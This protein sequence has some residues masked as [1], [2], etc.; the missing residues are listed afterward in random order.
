[1]IYITLSYIK[2]DLRAGVLQRIS[3][4]FVC[5]RKNCDSLVFPIQNTIARAEG[6]G[7]IQDPTMYDS[8]EYLYNVMKQRQQDTAVSI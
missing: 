7:D 8:V 5:D 1:M 2:S 6:R 4:K 3:I